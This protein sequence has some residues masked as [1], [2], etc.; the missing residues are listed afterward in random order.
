[1]L[2]LMLGMM[3]TVVI[4]FL[5][6][7]SA[8]VEALNSEDQHTHKLL[9]AA[10]DVGWF[11]TGIGGQIV[12]KFT[13]IDAV[14]AGELA[15]KKKSSRQRPQEAPNGLF[16]IFRMRKNALQ[17]LKTSIKEIIESVN[18]NILILV[19]ELDRCRPDYAISYLE[20]IKHVF[21]IKGIIFVIAVD[22][23]QLESSAKTSFG[24]DLNF[25]EYYRKFVQREVP[26][27]KPSESAYKK[28]AERYVEYYLD[29]ENERHCIMSI[30]YNRVENIVELISYMKMTPRQVQDVFRIMGHVFETDE[31]KKGKLY[32]CLGVGTI[33][34]AALRI[35]SLSVYEA[36]GGHGLRIIGAANYFRKLSPDHADWWFT[37]CL[38]G[39]GLDPKDVEGKEAQAIFREAGFVSDENGSERR[40]DFGQWYSGW[41]HSTKDRFKQIYLRIEQVAS[42]G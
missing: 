18:P 34:M 25:P 27:P 35:G 4:L 9:N 32:W 29:R 38:T 12:N 28:L 41:G 16:D 6:L 1:M 13:G 15:E 39:K 42:W 14:S 3:T 31:S 17:S 20:T 11:I 10:K 8:L 24:A 5:S 19:D 37:L 23:K 40:Y 26:L 7:V 30:D 36:L 33:L 21:D 22:R 2:K